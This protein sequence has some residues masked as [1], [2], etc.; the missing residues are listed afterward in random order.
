MGYLKKLITLAG[1]GT[2]GYLLWRFDARLVWAETSAVGIGFLLI[3]PFQVL[4]HALNALAWSFAFKPKDAAAVPLWRLV[5][6][7]MAGDGVNYLTPSGNIAGEFVRPGMIADLRP[8]VVTVTS[9]LVAKFTQ[10][11]GQAAFII[12]GILLV[13]HGRLDSMAPGQK[14]AGLTGSALICLGILTGFWLITHKGRIGDRVWKVTERFGPGVRESLREFVERHPGRLALSTLFFMLGYAWG[15]LEVMLICYFLSVPMDLSTALAIEVLSNVV[16]SVMFMV[17]AKIGTQEAGK[18]AIFAGLGLPARQGL[19]LGLIRHVR[20]LI[21][22][23]LGFAIYLLHQ[24]GALPARLQGSPR[25]ARA[26][27]AGG[28]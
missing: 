19:A 2:L 7:R 20:E 14:A 6:V 23:S 13:L 24:R 3:V 26:R 15:A 9:V 16:D 10:A 4:D 27:S 12:G 1:L 5:I 21:W 18:T 8:P 25:P 11:F 17:P 28:D 22:A